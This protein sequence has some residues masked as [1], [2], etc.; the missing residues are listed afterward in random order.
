MQFN[1][2]GPVVIS[3]NMDSIQ[4]LFEASILQARICMHNGHEEGW[5]PSITNDMKRFVEK[6]VRGHNKAELIYFLDLGESSSLSDDTFDNH[7]DRHAYDMFRLNAMILVDFIKKSFP[8][9][10]RVVRPENVCMSECGAAVVRESGDHVRKVHRMCSWR[11]VFRV[12]SQNASLNDIV[13]GG[14]RSGNVSFYPPLFTHIT[15]SDNFLCDLHAAYSLRDTTKLDEGLI[16]LAEFLPPLQPGE[17]SV[18]SSGEE[19]N[20]QKFRVQV[21]GISVGGYWST[22]VF[23]ESLGTRWTPACYRFIM[24]KREFSREEVAED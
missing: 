15:A 1:T 14:Q 18:F 2:N 12:A 9:A 21:R 19:P 8:D 4:Y 23:L 5:T 16:E 6:V 11:H 3:C 22:G 24:H 20:K 17:P 13:I 7:E 10:A